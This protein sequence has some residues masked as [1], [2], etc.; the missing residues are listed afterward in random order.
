MCTP[1]DV[2]IGHRAQARSQEV[3]APGAGNALGSCLSRIVA[4]A[5]TGGGG[6][7]LGGGGY[8][9]AT[10]L[11]CHRCRFGVLV[12]PHPPQATTTT[13]PDVASGHIDASFLGLLIS[14]DLE[15]LSAQAK[16]V[17]DFSGGPKALIAPHIRHTQAFVHILAET[18]K[19]SSAVSMASFQNVHTDDTKI[20]SG[21]GEL[22]ERILGCYSS[23]CTVILLASAA[24][25]FIFG[26]GSTALLRVVPQRPAAGHG[27]LAAMAPEAPIALVSLK[28]SLDDCEKDLRN[29]C[30]AS[31]DVA[32]LRLCRSIGFCA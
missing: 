4:I 26:G 2:P 3:Y 22:C 1:A 15:V 17:V 31:A 14:A 29:D 20:S 32:V 13:T 28:S 7:S 6:R 21:K 30:L 11:K 19:E 12:A 8:T 23:M 27:E 25:A 10:L 5:W 24:Q 9:L 16:K 18:A